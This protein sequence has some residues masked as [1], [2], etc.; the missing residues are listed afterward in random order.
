M[1]RRAHGPITFVNEEEGVSMRTR[2]ALP[3]LVVAVL[4]STASPTRADTIYVQN[5][6]SGGAAGYALSG[7]WHVTGNFPFSGQFDLG[8]VTGETNGPVLNGSYDTGSTNSGNAFTPGIVLPAAG[9]LRLTFEYVLDAESGTP[10]DSFSVL[11]NP[12][13]QSEIG[14]TILGSNGGGDLPNSLNYRLAV[15]DLTAFAGQT[16]FIGFRFDTVDAIANGFK[17]VRIDDVTVAL[18]PEPSSLVLLTLGG[19]GLLRRRRGK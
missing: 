7:L 3:A 15:F 19:V 8:Y 12:A 18:V 16:V 6:D 10:F 13:A 9:P 14:A 4:L 5:F 1:H 17:G 2:L 11:V